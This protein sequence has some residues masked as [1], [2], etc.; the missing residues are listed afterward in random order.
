MDSEVNC[1]S[2]I[3]KNDRCPVV[4]FSSFSGL[5]GARGRGQ[6]AVG[7]CGHAP[8]GSLRLLSSPSWKRPG[9]CHF[10]RGTAPSPAESRVKAEYFLMYIS[11]ATHWG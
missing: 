6:V 7:T 3:S 9:T 5:G 2:V 8:M 1:L 11:A 10:S 4:G